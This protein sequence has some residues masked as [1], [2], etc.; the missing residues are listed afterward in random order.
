MAMTLMRARTFVAIV[1]V[2]M[3]SGCSSMSPSQIGQTAGTIAGGAIAPGIG[4][5]I[6][7]LVGTLTGMVVEG[8]LDKARERK[9]HVELSNQLGGSAPLPKASTTMAALPL[10]AMTRVWVDEQLRDGRLVAGHFETRA[11]P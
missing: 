7:A 3:T 2:A 8:H 4:V 9:E 11:I 1:L 6:G 10:E 5:P